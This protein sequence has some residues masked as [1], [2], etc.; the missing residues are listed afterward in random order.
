[1]SIQESNQIG[2]I[3][4]AEALIRENLANEQFGVS[5]LADAMNMSRSNLLRKI[6]RETQLSASQFIREIRLQEGMELLKSYSELT[7]SE[8]SHQVGF[9]STSYFIKCFREQYGYPPGEV[10]KHKDEELIEEPTSTF[11]QR[12]RWY[13]VAGMCAVLVVA[14][15]FMFNNKEVPQEKKIVKS[16][17]VLPFKNESNDSTNLYFVNGLMESALNNLQKIEEL[18]V[19]SRTSVEKFRQT[20]LSAPE[21]A[22]ELNVNYLVEGSGQRVGNQ[23]LLN[24]Q[25]IEASTDTPIWVEQYNQEIVDIFALQNDVA[26]KIAVSIEAV[27]TPAELERIEKKPTDNLEAYDYYLKALEPYH[28]RTK[29]GLE[30]AVLL[31]EKAIKEDTQFARAYANIAISYY[32]LDIDKKHKQYTE[33]INNYAD[34][35]L[36]YDSKS[37]LSLIAKA[38]YYAQTDEYRLALPHL[39]KALEYNPNSTPVVQMLAD[40]YARAIPNTDKYL[41]YALKGVQLDIAAN[42]SVAKGYIYLHLSNALVQSGFVD[43]SITFINESLNYDPKN[44]YSPLVKVYVEYAKNENMEETTKQLTSE[45]SKDTTRLDLMQEVAKFH[46]FQEDYEKAFHYYKKFAD[47]REAYNLDIYPQEDIKISKVYK[48]MGLDKEASTFFNSYAEY[49]EKDQSIYK[50]ASMAVK[51]AYEGELDEA[52][53]QLKNFATE[54]NYQYWILLF[55]RKDPVMKPLQSH[56]EFDKTLQKIEDQF[57][58]NQA[59][60][61]KSLEEKELI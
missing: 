27:V 21:I 41:E 42:D 56:P 50:S 58:E 33:L 25:L 55:M 38:L 28:S 6:K 61:R 30:E 31:F 60:L 46:Y 5:E 52:M 53:E 20:N 26:K 24:I 19:I 17:A 16:I 2:F 1:M 47:S 7:V 13:L 36:L 57:W 11:V 51:Y 35:A 10:G 22:K 8:I 40:L 14:S 44:Y 18:R 48:E 37:D 23:V 9:G 54:D 15:Y 12:N 29:E 34:K 43:E 39:E 3:N 59:L 32:F 45:W 49:C 4:R